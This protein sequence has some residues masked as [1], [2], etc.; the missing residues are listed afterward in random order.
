MDIFILN[1]KD[2]KHPGAGGAEVIAFELAKRLVKAGN[3]VTFFSRSYPGCK[4]T[5]EISGIKIIRKG[6]ML[7]VYFHAFL[8]YMNLKNKPD[9]VIEMINT[10]AWF[11]PFYVEKHK[12]FAYLNQLA[13]E[14]W[15]YEF[16]FPLAITGYIVERVEYLFYKT[17]KFLCYSKST[18]EDLASF[19]IPPKNISVFPIG[20]DHDRYFKQGKKV[21]YPLFIFV[22]RLVSMK[23]ADLCILAMKKVVEKFSHAKLAIIGVG[24]QENSLKDLVNKLSLS[25]NVVFVTKDN[26]F[27]TKNSKDIKVKLMQSAWA[28]LLPSI[29]E[30]WG[31]VVTEAGACATPSIVSDVTGLRDSVVNNQT[32]IVLSKRPNENDLSKALEK[33]IED[34]RLRKTL[35][36]NAE[37]FANKFSWDRSFKE[38]I[39]ILQG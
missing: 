27:L 23:K 22:A 33:I 18:K 14:V 2:I 32:G 26:F 15:F 1:W 34:S 24:K 7:S 39:N 36:E 5:E 31:L 29:K 12:R 21:Q 10:I 13:N 9:K 20:I 35:S 6:G 8:Y 37:K 25:E 4:Q 3:T 17:T 30:G 16:P 11:T 28:L 19:G 38:F